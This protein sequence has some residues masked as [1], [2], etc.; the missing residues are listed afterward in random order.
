MICAS[1]N[2]IVVD[3]SIYDEVKE[4]LK[5]HGAYFLNDEQVP[6]FSKAFIDEKRG[7]VRGMLA[8]KSAKE[9][10][11]LCSLEVPADTR[12]IV[13]ELD[14]VGREYPLSAEKLSPVLSMY[15]AKDAKEAFFIV[16]NCLITADAVILLPFIPKIIT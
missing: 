15:K 16:S 1:E 10:A 2:S 9:I 11:T 5:G 4:L 13:A 7:T 8:G 14:G 3:A 12:I 6:E